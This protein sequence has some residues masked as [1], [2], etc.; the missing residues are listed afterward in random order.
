MFP[1][2]KG[3]LRSGDRF[4]PLRLPTDEEVANHQR[5]QFEF[6]EHRLLGQ[7]WTKEQAAKLREL[8]DI[9]ELPR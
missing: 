2:R 9:G 8:I 5:Q 6:I 3:P 1:Q 7:H 4:G